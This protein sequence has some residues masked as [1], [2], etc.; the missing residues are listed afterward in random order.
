MKRKFAAFYD[1]H[2]SFFNQISCT[3]IKLKLLFQKTSV[4]KLDKYNYLL[5]KKL[6][7]SKGSYNIL[8]KSQNQSR[9]AFGQPCLKC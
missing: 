7:V 4:K 3:I 6:Q 1:S 2:S 8:C 5:V 9:A